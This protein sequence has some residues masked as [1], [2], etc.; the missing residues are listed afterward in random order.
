MPAKADDG[1]GGL[2]RL[3][4]ALPTDAGAHG[5]VRRS[6]S[7]P[8]VATAGERWSR[9]AGR[10]C[11]CVRVCVCV[12]ARVCVYVWALTNTEVVLDY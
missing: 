12:C 10:T 5:R 6:A 3:Q 8:A 2:R 9:R 11:V 7:R 1:R 4:F